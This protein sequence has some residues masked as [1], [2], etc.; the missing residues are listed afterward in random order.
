MFRRRSPPEDDAERRWWETIGPLP[1]F[2]TRR[3][4]ANAESLTKS[5]DAIAQKSAETRA[6][7]GGRVAGLPI[8]E[9]L[10]LISAM[11]EIDARSYHIFQ[12]AEADRHFDARREAHALSLYDRV[13]DAIPGV[14]SRTGA[15]AWANRHHPISSSRFIDKHVSPAAVI[16][17]IERN[18]D[19]DD[20]TGG[21]IP[22]ALQAAPAPT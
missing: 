20:K 3:L 10:A 11:H 8:E 19:L 22:A 2:D 7:Y 4:F 12:F 1:A 14:E 18:W 15:V 5:I 6:R 13:R 16:D 17:L 9:R 21:L